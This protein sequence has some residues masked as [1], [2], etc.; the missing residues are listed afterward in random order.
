MMTKD[1]FQDAQIANRD[2][3]LC[4]TRLPDDYSGSI[5]RHD[6][7]GFMIACQTNSQLLNHD[8]RDLQDSSAE[9]E[10]LCKAISRYIVENVDEQNP[11]SVLVSLDFAIEGC[12]WKM[13][14][15]PELISPGLQIQVR[16]LARASRSVG[17]I[18]VTYTFMVDTQSR[19]ST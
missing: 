12:V 3:G 4:P 7:G 10:F 2:D 19:S 9:L 15:N 6:S 16:L 13:N 5:L 18:W 11:K 17:T 8:V 1:L 14:L